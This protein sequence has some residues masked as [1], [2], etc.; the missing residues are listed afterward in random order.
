M[1]STGYFAS[2]HL[3]DDSQ[4]EIRRLKA[5]LDE[6]KGQSQP[7][8]NTSR[9]HLSE[10]DLEEKRS[11]LQ[12]QIENLQPLPELLKQ[13]EVKNEGLQEQIRDLEKRLADR[14]TTDTRRSPSD[15]SHRMQQQ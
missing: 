10:L 11:R 6:S 3:A 8:D 2:R 9:N 5:K 12:K 4:E 1:S 13:A 14:S 15:D 7:L